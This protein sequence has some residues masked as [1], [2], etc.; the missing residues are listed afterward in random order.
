MQLV[1]ASMV[2]LRGLDSKELNR[3]GLGEVVRASDSKECHLSTGCFVES[4]VEVE[5]AQ[6]G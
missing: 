6:N 1:V 2:H 4:L 5:K 3:P